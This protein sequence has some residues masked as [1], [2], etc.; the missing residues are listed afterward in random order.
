MVKTLYLKYSWI[1]CFEQFFRIGHICLEQENTNTGGGVLC[2]DS[3]ALKFRYVTNISIFDQNFDFW[4]KFRFLSNIFIFDQNFDFWPKFRFV[5]K[6]FTF[7][8][9]FDFWPKFQFLFK[10]FMFDQNFNFDLNFDFWPKFQ[11]STNNNFKHTFCDTCSTFMP[12]HSLVFSATRCVPVVR[13]TIREPNSIGISYDIFIR[14]KCWI[15]N[16]KHVPVNL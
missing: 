3:D 9:N 16:I 7:D 12:G 6:I 8:Q 4:A 1:Y 15:I 14:N 5:S 13:N 10:I 2:R 11:F